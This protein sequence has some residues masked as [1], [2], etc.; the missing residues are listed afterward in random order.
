MFSSLIK[1]TRYTEPYLE[2]WDIFFSRVMGGVTFSS[3]V[4]S[5]SVFT[6]FSSLYIDSIA[7]SMS[8]ARVLKALEMADRTMFTDSMFLS[9]TWILD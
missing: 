2:F 7:V 9:I 8:A 1:R 4:N 6:C 3:D 5:T